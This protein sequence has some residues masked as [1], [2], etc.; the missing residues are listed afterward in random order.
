MKYV[1]R[2]V[3]NINDCGSTENLIYTRKG[4][5]LYI[6]SINY[7]RIKFPHPS[8]INGTTINNIFSYFS[9]YL[10]IFKKKNPVIRESQHSPF[11]F[12]S[13]FFGSV[14]DTRFSFAMQM[15]PRVHPRSRRPG[16][17]PPRRQS[18]QRDEGSH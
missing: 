15:F 10:K 18:S 13:P 12:L 9:K 2:N 8:I 4:I 7:S 14:Q 11:I 5:Q 17:F 6:R 16:F 1:H 3:I